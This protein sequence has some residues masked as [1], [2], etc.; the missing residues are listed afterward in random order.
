[1]EVTK[2]PTQ[3]VAE[4]PAQMTKVFIWTL[5]AVPETISEKI[6]IFFNNNNSFKW[7]YWKEVNFNNHKVLQLK[8]KSYKNLYQM[9]AKL[10]INIIHPTLFSMKGQ[11][12]LWMILTINQQ[13]AFLEMQQWLSL[14]WIPT[15]MIIKFKNTLITSIIISKYK[16]IILDKDKSEWT[17]K[18]NLK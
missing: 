1:M 15:A 6:F 14:I 12:S 17:T 5:T 2:D 7:I 9:T 3:L 16:K 4:L 18:A 10:I 8:R 13:S 11:I